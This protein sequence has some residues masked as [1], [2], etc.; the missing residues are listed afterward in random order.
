MNGHRI[1]NTGKLI[2]LFL[3]SGFLLIS[4]GDSTTQP[5]NGNNG[6]DLVSPPQAPQ[7]F[8]TIAM[9]LSSILLIWEDMSTNETGFE[10]YESVDDD[11]S[12]VLIHQ[13]P[14]NVDSFLITDVNLSNKYYY[15]I[16]AYNEYGKS[17]FTDVAG[18]AG[19]SFMREIVAGSAL[20]PLAID[21]GPDGSSLLSGWADYKTRRYDPRTGNLIQ[22]LV[23]HSNHV[24]EVAY[25]PDGERFASSSDDGTVKVWNHYRTA[26]EHVFEPS[27][28]F[29]EFSPD[30]QYLALGGDVPRVYRMSDGLLM[31]QDSV[32]ADFM[33]YTS[34]E[35]FIL[36]ERNQKIWIR[37]PITGDSLGEIRT[38]NSKLALS[39]D[40]EYA[41]AV[42][43]DDKIAL[44]QIIESGDVIDFV[45]L[46]R[47]EGHTRTIKALDFSYDSKWLASGS[48]DWTV[49]VW[50]VINQ[51]NRTTLSGHSYGVYD[52]DF[53]PDGMYLATA[54]GDQKIILWNAFF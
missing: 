15:K 10:I 11:T 38:T 53:S 2:F 41:A 5:G 12:F 49:K 44:Y 17:A 7:D 37:D 13:T 14:A 26:Q 27:A 28:G 24:I 1:S 47:L 20:V 46:I 43:D 42:V 8:R 21:F 48:L 23:W 45:W 34:D 51:V 35:R 31:W 32:G 16:C 52:L 33:K 50:D 4:C 18:I 30:G 19:G 22:E 9:S 29:L 25:S 54:S 39:P 40:G 6:N 3:I 36:A